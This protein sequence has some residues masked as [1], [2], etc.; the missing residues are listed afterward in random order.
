MT[1]P[2]VGVQSG[3]PELARG[4][5]R[6]LWGL[7]R[8]AAAPGGAHRPSAGAEH[9]GQSCRQLR[10]EG[11]HVPARWKAP[12]ECVTPTQASPLQPLGLQRVENDLT[13]EA[14]V[15]GDLPRALMKSWRTRCRGR[16]E[17]KP[18]AAP[19]AAPQGG[20]PALQPGDGTPAARCPPGVRPSFGPF[21]SLPGRSP[22]RVLVARIPRQDNR[23]SHQ[24]RAPPPRD[25]VPPSRAGSRFP[26]A[27]ADT[28]RLL[29]S[30]PFRRSSA[31]RGS[32][33]ASPAS[34]ARPRLGPSSAASSSA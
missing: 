4:D 11:R 23:D 19:G 24:R 1:R 9:R 16:K 29:K 5:G 34:P 15:K 20:T 26:D 12:Q 25:W 7:P 31:H 14:S 32:G 3:T 13:R 22:L 30:R 2:L 27:L 10:R 28:R 6:R 17:P 33:C 8:V 18:G 21:S